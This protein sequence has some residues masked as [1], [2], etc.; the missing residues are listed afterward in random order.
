MT[1]NNLGGQALAKPASRDAVNVTNGTESP[2]IQQKT[3]VFISRVGLNIEHR[4]RRGFARFYFVEPCDA[5][6]SAPYW[7]GE[8]FDSYAAAMRYCASRCF[9]V[10]IEMSKGAIS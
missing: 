10:D 4:G 2:A 6:D 1:E 5:S 7:I 8:P 3:R 9:S